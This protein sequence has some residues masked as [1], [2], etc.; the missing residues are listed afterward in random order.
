[1]S[2]EFVGK[3]GVLPLKDLIDRLERVVSKPSLIA[4]SWTLVRDALVHL[5]S[6]DQLLSSIKMVGP[7]DSKSA[8]D[9][10]CHWC[11]ILVGDD[12]FSTPPHRHALSCDAMRLRDQ[13]AIAALTGSI[14]YRIV[15]LTRAPCSANDGQGVY[16]DNRSATMFAEEAY[17]VADAMMAARLKV[18]P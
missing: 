14:A 17:R 7:D 6:T 2:V 1:M 12:D 3:D 9:V 13:F 8:S 15:N 10:R 5:R 11:D 4:S 18:K 16:I